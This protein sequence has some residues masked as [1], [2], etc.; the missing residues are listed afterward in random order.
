[1][2]NEQ[3]C[4]AATGDVNLINK[5]LSTMEKYGE[6]RWWLSDDVKRMCFFQLQEDTLLIEFEVLHTGT[7]LLLGR[8]VYVIEFRDLGK[9]FE[10]AKTKY[11]PA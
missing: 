7:Q 3:Y 2:T 8:E 4:K 9:L 11:N 1:M 5:M 6:N 10:E